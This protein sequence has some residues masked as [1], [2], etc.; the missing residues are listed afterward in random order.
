MNNRLL[1]LVI[2]LL[3]IVGFYFKLSTPSQ[4][5]IALSTE[6]TV[7]AF[8]DSLTYGFGAVESAYP[9]Q[10]AELIEREVINAGIS[11]EVSS[12]ALLR[13]PRLL[14]LY[15][16]DLVILCHGGNDILRHASKQQLKVNL[17]KMVS[18]IK[19][20]GAEVLLVGVPGFGLFGIATLPLYEEV[21]EEANLLYEGEVLEK[22][23]NNP[24]LKSDRIHPNAKG[25]KMM[26]EAF[27]T[28][29]RDQGLL[30]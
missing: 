16:P 30:E 7:L 2:G 9:K 5:R 1:A 26:V 14:E 3:F 18:L 19:K 28:L 13:L 17:F 8:G 20:S 29:L 22:I 27:A 23:E 4:E 10:L 21:A 25:Y 24:S 11:G 15:H 12:V 6:S